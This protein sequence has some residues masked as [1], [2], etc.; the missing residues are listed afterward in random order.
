MLPSTKEAMSGGAA[1]TERKF[2]FPIALKVSTALTD[3]V[4][5]HQVMV[6]SET[7]PVTSQEFPALSMAA[8]YRHARYEG[9]EAIAWQ[10][11]AKAKADISALP[12]NSQQ[13]EHVTRTCS[14]TVL[15]HSCLPVGVVINAGYRMEESNPNLQFLTTGDITI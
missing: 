9:D 2:L 3:D 10:E 15:R 13:R 11:N 7:S 8:L 12:H 14:R 1:A 5:G 6:L 4:I